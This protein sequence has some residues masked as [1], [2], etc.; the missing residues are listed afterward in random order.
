MESKPVNRMNASSSS[1]SL[2]VT[3]A[4]IVGAGY[5]SEFHARAL[6]ALPNV[7]LVSVCDTDLG[8][9]KSFAN[10]WGVPKAFDSLQSMLA[11]EQIDVVHVLTPPDL[12]FSVA[13]SIL[14][15]GANVFLEKPMCTSSLETD[16]LVEIADA[17]ARLIGVNHNFLFS[18]AYRILR[19]AVRSGALGPLDHL[20]LNYLYELGPIRGGP[21]DTWMLRSPENVLLEIGSHLISMVLDLV[22]PPDALSVTAD[23]T[24]RL[25]NGVQVIRRWRIQMTAGRSALDININLGPGFSQ[26]TIFAR[27]LL[28]AAVLDF[29]ANT[30]CVDS[31][32]PLATDMDRYSRSLSLA[33]QLRRQA[34]QTLVDYALTKLKL[35]ERGNSYQTSILD[36][37]AAFYAR[38]ESAE[39]IDGRISG[40]LGSDVILWCNRI[41]KAA[42]IE[43]NSVARPWSP[44]KSVVQPTVLVIGGSG[45]IGRELVRKLLEAGYGLRVMTR[46]SS[47]ALEGLQNGALETIRGDLR[48]EADLAIALKGIEFVYDL[49]TSE[50]KT[51]DASLRDVVEPTRVLGEACAAANVRRIIYTGT[52]DSYYAG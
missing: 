50:A 12:H 18:G 47:A 14:N 2:R 24:I 19:D 46:G 3:R 41:I 20:S 48:K 21:F 23:R 17:N 22:G 34:R 32:T 27:G 49:A 52:I 4:A 29:D 39:P 26:R 5:I 6:R 45:F 13:K 42:G 31:R 44:Q 16:E 30:C 38:L 28:G 8:R 40:R 7:E 15:A 25:P 33:R 11:D 43:S 51:W 1:S 35:R 9:A 37:I 36:S 10:E